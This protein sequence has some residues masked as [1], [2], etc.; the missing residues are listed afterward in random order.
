MYKRQGW[1]RTGDLIGQTLVTIDNADV[2]GFRKAAVEGHSGSM[3]SVAIGDTGKRA[4]VFGTRTPVSYTH[5]DVYKRQVLDKRASR[6]L[7]R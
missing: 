7:V 4:L 2:P 5:L 6:W 3:R 1:G